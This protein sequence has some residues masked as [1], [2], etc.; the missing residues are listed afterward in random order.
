MRA[1]LHHGKFEPPMS[2]LRQSHRFSDVG[3]NSALPPTPDVSRHRSE[4]P[5]RPQADSCTAANSVVI[6]SPLLMTI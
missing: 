1:A 2:Q 4:R 5:K 3:D 6:Q